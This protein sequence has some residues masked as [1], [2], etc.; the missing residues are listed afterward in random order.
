[1][2]EKKKKKV[3]NKKST[4][5]QCYRRLGIHRKKYF[6]FSNQLIYISLS[7]QIYTYPSYEEVL[8]SDKY[9]LDELRITKFGESSAITDI[10]LLYKKLY[11][12]EY[13]PS[14]YNK[15][16]FEHYYIPPSIIKAY[17]ELGIHK[18]YN[19]Q[20]ECL[21]KIFLND[22]IENKIKNGIY[23]KHGNNEEYVSNENT[24]YKSNVEGNTDFSM[25]LNFFCDM[26]IVAKKNK[27]YTPVKKEDLQTD[28]FTDQIK[29]DIT[30]GRNN[31]NGDNTVNYMDDK[32]KAHTND[33]I[34]QNLRH[35]TNECSNEDTNEYNLSSSH[36]KCDTFDNIENSSYK[37]TSQ[38]CNLNN[39]QSHKFY[40][41]FLFKIPTG[42]GKTLIYDIL[43]IR[44]VLYKGFRV[45]LTLPTLSLIN[46][47]YEYYDKLFG[48]K[49]VSLN[50]KKFNS[51]DFTGYSY[52]LSTDLALCT[53]EQANT[54]LSI[55]I[56][57]NLK[58]NYLFILD[59]IHYINNQKRGFYIESLLT[60]I[61]YIQKNFS[62]IYNIKAY[63]FSA[64]LSNIDQLAEWLE[65]NVY[66][67]KTKLQRIKYLYKI[68]NSLYK[69][70]NKKE[71]ERTLENCNVLDPNHLGY[72]MSEEFILK[73]NVL[74][75]CP[76][77]N[78]SEQTASFIST[79]LP[80]Y[81]NKREYK[82]NMELKEKRFK[83]LKDLKDLTIKVANVEKMIMN[84]IFYHHSGLN[85]NEKSIIENS[86][87]NNILFCL[88]C[89]TTLSV[90]INMN[91][92]TII[93]RSLKLGKSFI[94]KD[95]I[96]QMAGRCGRS[97]KKMYD[98]TTSCKNLDDSINKSSMTT[99]DRRYSDSSGLPPI[100]D[101]DYDC[102]GKVIIFVSNAEKHYLEKILYDEEETSKLKTTLNNFQMCK[103]LLD[104]IHLKLI[105]TKKEM[106]DFLYLYSIKFFKAKSMEGAINNAIDNN[107][108]NNNNN[109]NIGINVSEKILIDVKQT[110]QY[111]FENKL[112]TIPY[113]QEKNYYEHVFNKI[114]NINF[115][116]INKIFD[117][118]YLNQT[119]NPNILMKYNIT[120]KINIFKKLYHNYKGN[121][122]SVDKQTS[123][124]TLPFITI[125]LIFKDIEFNKNLFQNLYVE[126][127]K[128][129]FLININLQQYDLFVYDILND[130]D[131][132]ACTELFSYVQSA[133]SIMEFIFNYSIVK[134]I[135]VK[136]FPPDVL[137]M[138]FAFCI[139]SEINLKIHF[140][141]YEQ[142]LMSQNKN[143]K[144][145]F[146][147]FGLNVEKLK[148]FELKNVD[149][150][151]DASASI[152][153]GKLNI[154]QI[155]ENLEWIKIKRFYYAMIIYDC[156]ND[157]V[158]QVAK[159]YRLKLKEIKTVYLRCI[160]NLS[161]N[162]R[163]LKNF[164]NSL[165][166]FCIVLENLLAKMK[167]KSFPFI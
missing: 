116:D 50:I 137:L 98:S 26:N 165:D 109:N 148:N 5:L 69:D 83:L 3:K 21:C 159:K 52:S 133:S 57:N 115:C 35:N 30:F 139:N 66:E 16:N 60:K 117:F 38:I 108:N 128:Y 136:G 63:G 95:E 111:L 17:N 27:N 7:G 126:F 124:F 120:Q 150:L 68:D 39:N 102:D 147:F 31:K 70:I 97:Q 51:N 151:F 61:K 155:Y 72:M 81:L 118:Q 162:C 34:H 54:I 23:M 65:A 19:E 73:K 85:I 92:H 18:L 127:I 86:F 167:T 106:F 4:H 119:I 90:G 121:N 14:N 157:D 77:K 112:I 125:L 164:K 89:T 6:K 161:Y 166:I 104:F 22:D 1:M 33:N 96:T 122:I 2:F 74:I 9:I 10:K 47:K 99:P 78:K 43:I 91:I 110:F 48:D 145:I 152:I 131:P 67:S 59:E 15:Q 143:I 101:Y 13:D 58:F 24:H 55:I 153:K 28:E 94:T 49:T 53:F 149:D 88:C 40:N 44:Q 71:V 100:L 142:I 107:N 75:F 160:F 56:K 62:H 140:D 130:D 20:A 8:Q 123:F 42:M 132:I 45:I 135:Y 113:E 41:N 12:N 93:I 138:I 84:G 87:R 141:I 154:D 134:Y 158:Y 79:I 46:E 25:N 163:I 76:S 144:N 80:Y 64:T 103:F 36:S 82:I 29:S 105:K 114:F 32:I 129:L 37:K 11:K 156:Y 146:Q